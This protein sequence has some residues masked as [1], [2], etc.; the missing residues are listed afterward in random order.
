MRYCDKGGEYGCYYKDLSV[1]SLDSSF[2]EEPSLD[3]EVLSD[4]DFKL[5][6]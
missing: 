2:E 3:E 6:L 1:G 5:D 4:I